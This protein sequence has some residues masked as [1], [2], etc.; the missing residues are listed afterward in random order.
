MI[1]TV[2]GTMQR[3]GAFIQVLPP[4]RM[5]GAILQLTGAGS[6]PNGRHRIALPQAESAHLNPNNS[7]VSHA[8]CTFAFQRR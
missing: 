6:C 2:R 5:A 8:A 3:D 1:F 4:H 7:Q